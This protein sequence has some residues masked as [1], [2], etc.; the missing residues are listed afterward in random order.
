MPLLPL[1]V[2]LLVPTCRSWTAS[3]KDQPAPC[4]GTHRNHIAHSEHRQIL[5]GG[6]WGFVG[7]ALCVQ[8]SA[9]PLQYSNSVS[10]KAPTNPHFKRQ[11]ARL[12]TQP[13]N[14]DR[15]QP[16]RT[17][18]LKR[19]TK[20]VT[21]SPPDVGGIRGQQRRQLAA[22][23]LILVKP[24]NVLHWWV[25]GVEF[26]ASLAGSVVRC[27][28]RR[29]RLDLPALNTTAGAPAHTQDD[30]PSQP[31]WRRMARNS[32]TRTRRANACVKDVIL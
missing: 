1:L 19:L 10:T 28:Q 7:T 25:G 23:I 29:G 13:P 4:P 9:V 30:R 24:T 26:A 12:P 27:Q 32:I 21:H 2:L 5:N 22:G 3:H 17:T 18:P 11:L 15:P 31:T 20:H 8:R 16:P 14:A 6:A